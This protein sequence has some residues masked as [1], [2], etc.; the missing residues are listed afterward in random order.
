MTARPARGAR[1]RFRKELAWRYVV[2]ALALAFAGFPILFVLS[3]SLDPIGSVA[4]TSLLPTR[5]V[6]LAN[7]RALFDGSVGPFGRWYL[8]TLIVCSVVAAVQIVCSTSAAYAFSRLRF[9][10]RRGGLLSLLLI[11]MFPNV[12]A[13]IA[14][15]NLFSEIGQVVP[16]VG[17]STVLGYCIAMTGGAL[18]QVWLIKGAMDSIP[19]S[20]DE[21]AR[22][23]GAG[24]FVIFTRILLPVIKPIIATTTLLAFVGVI[25]EFLIGSLFLRDSASKTLAVGLFGLLQSDR[26][27]NLGVFAA[28]AVLTIIP[29]VLLFQYLQRHIVSDSTSGAVKG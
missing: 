9:R 26:S 21:A 14:I 10:G 16:A 22:I 18:G 7:Y 11:M 3:A 15:F 28:G 27:A 12:L 29:V 1:E 8:N 23:D 20:L 13:M 25:S 5:G 19:R 24:H 4:S 2:A 6:S 17:L